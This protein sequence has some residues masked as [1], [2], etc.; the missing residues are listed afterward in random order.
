MLEVVGTS[1]AQGGRGNA[2][3]AE[4][5]VALAPL[6]D[7]LVRAGAPLVEVE[8]PALLEYCL[9]I[10]KGPAVLEVVEAWRHSEGQGTGAVAQVVGATASLEDVVAV[11]A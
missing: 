6:E 2:T 11:F 5:V 3:A 9:R 7:V 8:A 1:T 10:F 4:E